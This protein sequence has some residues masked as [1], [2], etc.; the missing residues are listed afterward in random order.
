MALIHDAQEIAILTGKEVLDIGTLNEAY[1]QRLSLLH[2]YIEPPIV[3]KK[4]ITKRKKEVAKI[5][6]QTDNNVDLESYS[7]SAIAE[8]AKAESLDVVDLLKKVCNVIEV[9]V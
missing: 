1:Q 7:I 9:A 3:Q 8:K 6:S 4:T 5:E 2:S